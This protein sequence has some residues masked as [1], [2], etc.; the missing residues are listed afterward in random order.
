MHSLQTVCEKP[1]TQRIIRSYV[2][3]F[4]EKH[5]DRGTINGVVSAR[6]RRGISGLCA[7]L[8]ILDNAQLPGDFSFVSLHAQVMRPECLHVIFPIDYPNFGCG[9]SAL[10]LTMDPKQLVRLERVHFRA[11]CEKAED[12]C[13]VELNKIRL[14]HVTPKLND[15]LKIPVG[16]TKVGTGHD[17]DLGAVAGKVERG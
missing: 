3:C 2:C 12:E 13:A 6:V 16:A 14:S 5:F 15:V 9:P 17:V 1:P 10:S 4:V 8:G 7:T 11:G